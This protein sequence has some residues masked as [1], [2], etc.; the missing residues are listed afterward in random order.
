MHPCTHVCIPMWICTR[1]YKH[2]CMHGHACMSVFGHALM[3]PC[4]CVHIHTYMHTW[5]HA[6]AY[7]Y[8]CFI[9]AC[10][11]PTCICKHA[12]AHACICTCKHACKV[13][14]G[15]VCTCIDT[16]M[17]PNINVC[18]HVC[19]C[20]CMCGDVYMHGHPCMGV[21]AH[22]SMHPCMCA[23]IHMFMHASACAH[24]CMHVRNIHLQAYMCTCMRLH[25]QPCLHTRIMRNYDPSMKLH[26]LEAVWKYRHIVPL[27][28]W[29]NI[30]QY[31]GP[32]CNLLNECYYT[33]NNLQPICQPTLSGMSLSVI[34]CFMSMLE[35]LPHTSCT[36]I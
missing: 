2:V 33:Q 26:D 19:I 18:P 5:P 17:D 4:M 8:P 36:C 14:H 29:D 28:Y 6:H 31:N 12:C 22:A 11:C 1:M 10:M 35:G 3:H 25:M 15:Y 23:H 20:T 9:G 13:T 16:Y 27:Q 34:N 32:T 21:F 30:P 7:V 24:A